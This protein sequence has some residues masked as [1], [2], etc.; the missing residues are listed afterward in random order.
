MAAD[1]RSKQYPARDVVPPRGSENP[2]GGSVTLRT[3]ATSS[4]FDL[5]VVAPD[6]SV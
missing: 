4:S 2:Q 6:S 5:I 3:V 1:R